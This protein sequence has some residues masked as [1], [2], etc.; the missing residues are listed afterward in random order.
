MHPPM[1]GNFLSDPPYLIA[2][3]DAH[4]AAFPL[5]GVKCVSGLHV[6]LLRSVDL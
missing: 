6:S 3:Q 2:E 5:K 1:H 4:I